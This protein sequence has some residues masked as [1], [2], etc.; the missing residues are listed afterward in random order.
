M[1]YGR[2]KADNS[3][4]IFYVANIRIPTEKAHGIQIMK[5]CEALGEQGAD[6]KLIVS[7]RG[8]IASN[9]EDLFD[10]YRL[11]RSFFIKRLFSPDP[12]WLMKLPDGIYIKLQAIFFICALFI[13]LLFI[14]KKGAV[15]YTRDEYLLPILQIFFS[16]VVWEGHNLPRRRGYYKRFWKKCS[17]LIV[18][19]HPLKD[20]LIRLGVESEKIHVLPDSV[21]LSIFDISEKK[22]EAKIKLGLPRDKKI[23]M[24]TGHLYEWKGAMLLLDTAYHFQVYFKDSNNVLFVFVGGTK[25]D[26]ENFKNQAENRG[27]HNIYVAGFR[28]YSEIPL[29]MKVADI[30]VLPNTS[31]EKISKLYTSPMKMFEYMASRKPIVASDLPSIREILNEGNCKFF[32]PDDAGE[33]ALAILNVLKNE[34]FSRQISEKAYVDVREYTWNK[35]AK[36]ALKIILKYAK[37]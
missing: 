28:P 17:G 9:K 24:Y 26:I 23:V 36:K 20:A 33:L 6:L 19:T 10:H 11:K 31:K 4:K 12:R 8:Y 35:R 29:W 32:K 5:M 13:Y 7:R 14:K 21:D 15:A 37:G 2:W 3:M 18:L 30:L 27:I 1:I 25:H 22:D 34:E 16:N